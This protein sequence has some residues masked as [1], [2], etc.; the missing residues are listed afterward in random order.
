MSERDFAKNLIDQI[1]ESRLY[2]IIAC[3][4]D[5]M[6]PD[7]TPNADTIAAFDELDSGGGNRFA[8]TTE[9]LFDELLTED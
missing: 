2:Y 3:L 4:R 9:Q 1:P 7:E 5:A 6:I 8:G